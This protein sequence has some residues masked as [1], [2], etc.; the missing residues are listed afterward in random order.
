MHDIWKPYL[1]YLYM[2]IYSE[3]FVACVLSSV[4]QIMS[5]ITVSVTASS[6]ISPSG[7]WLLTGKLRLRTFTGFRSSISA[8]NNKAERWSIRRKTAAGWDIL[9]EWDLTE[10]MRGGEWEKYCSGKIEG[11]EDLLLSVTG[12]TGQKYMIGC[13]DDFKRHKIR[14]HSLH[15][16]HLFH[17]VQC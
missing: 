4:P 8:G 12:V 7:G 16:L 6:S 11:D 9:G 10:G 15:F 1:C 17:G 5:G 13:R 14:L 3:E 2:Y